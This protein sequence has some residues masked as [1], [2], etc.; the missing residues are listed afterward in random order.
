MKVIKIVLIV[1]S[2]ALVSTGVNAAYVAGDIV[3]DISFLES[4]GGSPVSNSI[5]SVI[6]NRKVLIIEFGATW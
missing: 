5:Y 3:N 4:D 6:D 1:I 2:I